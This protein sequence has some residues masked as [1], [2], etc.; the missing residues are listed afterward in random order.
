[1]YGSGGSGSDP[2]KLFGSAKPTRVDGFGDL[3]FT[4]QKEKPE[5][6]TQGIYDSLDFVG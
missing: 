4:Y 2:N 3:S 6:D 1:M 5:N